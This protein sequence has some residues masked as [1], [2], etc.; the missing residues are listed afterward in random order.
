LTRK[1]FLPTL[2]ESPQEGLSGRAEGQMNIL[3]IWVIE[4]LFE[5]RIFASV[6]FFDPLHFGEGRKKKMANSLRVFTETRD[7]DTFG[8][9]F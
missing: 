9:T 4:L 7:R 3:K 5:F 6:R 2:L 8:L 1:D